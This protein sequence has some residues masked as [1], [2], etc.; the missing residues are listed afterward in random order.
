MK[1]AEFPKGTKITICSTKNNSYYE[2]QTEI[3]ASNRN[4]IAA[5][6]V[7]VDGKVVRF[8][9]E[10]ARHVVNVNEKRKAYVF[11]Q[12]KLSMRRLSM[13]RNQFVI[14]IQ[15]DEDVR[16]VNRRD[17]FRVFLGVDGMMKSGKTTRT[18]EVM[19]KDVSAGGLGVMCPATVHVPLQSSVTVTFVDELTGEKFVLECVVV[20]REAQREQ[21]VLYGCQL[22]KPSDEMEKFV[23]LRQR[24]H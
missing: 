1:L 20:R 5:K 16:A 11:Q 17:F 18:Q 22:P 8:S 4:V 19:V 2:Y 15:S 13:K 7:V 9:S 24:V 10:T 14:C 21:M 3:I 23:A 6:P 12:V